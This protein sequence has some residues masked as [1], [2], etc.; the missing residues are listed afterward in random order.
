VR[1]L[2][3][4]AATGQGHVTAARG[5]AEAM[6][7]AGAQASVLDAG[8]H[9]AIRGGAAAYN[10]FLRRPPAFMPAF[11]AAIERLRVAEVG[12]LF[13][14]SWAYDVLRRER[15]DVVVSVHPTLNQ[16]IARMLE[17]RAPGVPLAVV[18]TDLCP[19]F[20]RGWAEPFA[21]LTVAPTRPAAEEMAR[22]GVASQRL[23]VLGMPVA[24]RFRR[25]AG[26][27]ER[28]EARV[29]LG[30]DADRFTLLVSAGSAGRA[31][32]LDVLE[33]L[34]D[35][36]DLAARIQ[37][38]FLAGSSAALR[39]R[40]ASAATPFPTV[41]LGWRDDMHALLD[42]ADVLFTKPGGLTLAEALGKGVP[43]LLDGIGGVFPQERGGAAWAERE[44]V[45]WL[46]RRAADVAAILRGTPAAEW[47]ARRERCAGVL[48]GDAGTIAERI[49]AVA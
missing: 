27:Q 3:V 16:G 17:R 40:A 25:P 15:P 36:S 13:L 5:L 48:P 20:W 23:A 31:T 14:R 4:T 26:A 22:L 7:A 19:P 42:A 30:L 8:E 21:A 34:A 49:R 2:I 11:Y 18:L 10:F 33:A 1:V 9:P 46:V 45:A 29:R 37:V 47:A 44:R 38:V 6:A 24:A 28:R 39:R 41:V 43:L 32:S 35:S 12:G